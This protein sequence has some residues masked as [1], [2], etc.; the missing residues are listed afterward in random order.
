[1]ARQKSNNTRLVYSTESGRISE[2]KKAPY[3]PKSDGIIRVRREVKGRGG[4]TV[5]TIS[6]L[7]LGGD[8]LKQL[9]KELKNR[10]GTG[11]SIKDGIIVIQGDHVDK[12]IE[13][14][15]KREYTVKRS[16]G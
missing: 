14:L 1:M 16:G 12:L 4:K 3:R 2:D 13:E 10:C 5:S 7:I 15:K 6:G 11:G 8:G 9:A